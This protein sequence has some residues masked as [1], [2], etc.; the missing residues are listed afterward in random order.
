MV[1][2]LGVILLTLV[3]MLVISKVSFL[4]ASQIRLILRNPQENIRNY[5]CMPKT[6]HNKH[7]T[8]TQKHTHKKHKTQTNKRKHKKWRAIYAKLFCLCLVCLFCLYFQEF[9][10]EVGF[11][12]SRNSCFYEQAAGIQG[13][14]LS[15]G[16][17]TKYI[18]IYI[19]ISRYISR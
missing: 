1:V 17:V 4:S 18:Y 10:C 16:W 12:I 3:L 5:R 11:W 8:N 9:S 14:G 19:Y 13:F 7:T 2:V 15:W 6:K